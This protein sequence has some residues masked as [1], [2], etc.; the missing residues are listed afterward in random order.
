VYVIA[1]SARGPAKIGVAE[2]PVARLSGL[3]SAHP[4]RLKI[5]YAVGTQSGD[6][7]FRIEQKVLQDLAEF[8]MIGEWL[9]LVPSLLREHVNISAKAL[10][11]P[12]KVWKPTKA[13]LEQRLVNLKDFARLD[14][15]RRGEAAK[16]EA[17]ILNISVRE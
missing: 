4:Y 7:A 16:Q 1:W 8:R 14:E 9:K 6:A 5:Y 2:N 3:Q 10:G 13:Q 17:K 15:L 11:L 12:T